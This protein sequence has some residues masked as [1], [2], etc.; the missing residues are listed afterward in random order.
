MM[1]PLWFRAVGVALLFAFLR[2]SPVLAAEWS[3]LGRLPLRIFTDRDGLP[4]NAITAIT[5]AKDGALWVGTKDGAAR[6]NGRVWTTVSMPPG[7]PSNW[8]NSILQASDGALWFATR[9]GGVVRFKD[10]TWT[11]YSR[12]EGL[13][14]TE[15]LALIESTV[16][17]EPAS[18]FAGTADGLARFD[19][20]RFVSMG[21]PTASRSNR[22]TSLFEMKEGPASTLWVGT[23]EGILRFR[24]GQWTIFSVPVP[25]TPANNPV[26]G[27]ALTTA[28]D[29][30]PRL[31][32]ALAY[33]G[34]LRFDAST[35]RP[36]PLIRSDVGALQTLLVTRGAKGAES[37]W[38]GAQRRLLR[39]EGGKVESFGSD[40]GFPEDGF[41]SLAETPSDEAEKALW[42]GM[43]GG[44]LV[45]WK[46]DGWTTFD[47]TRWLKDASVYALLETIEPDGREAIWVG[48]RGG[49]VRI[50]ENE[51]ATFFGARQ[52]GSHTILS[53]LETRSAT[54]ERILWVGTTAG[55]AV[56]RGT[57]WSLYT[58][59]AGL[60][61]S[62]VNT[63]IASPG[64]GG[65]T[66]VWIGTG[67]GLGRFEAGRVR[68]VTAGMGLPDPRVNVLLETRTKAG[69]RTL[70]IGTE[71]GLVRREK[72][73]S[74]IFT[75]REGLPADAILSLVESREGGRRMLWIGTRGGAAR[76]DL[77]GSNAFTTFTTQTQ[78][79]LP[80][81]TVYQVR[82][83]LQER[84]YLCTNKGVARLTP[85]PRNQAE[86]AEYDSYVFTTQ[87]GLPS[88]ECNTGASMVDSKGRIWVGTINGAAVLEPRPG[89]VARARPL[90]IERAILSKTGAALQE[91]ASLAYDQ[92]HV[93]FDFA[94][95]NLFRDED[96]RYRTQLTGLDAEP[97]AWTADAKKEFTSLPEGR[98]GFEVWARDVTGAEAGPVRLSFSVRPAP[99]RTWW[100]YL[101][102]AA[103]LAASISHLFRLR[104]RAARR[105]NEEL[106]QVISARTSELGEAVLRLRDSE[107]SALQ[108]KDAA[109][110]ASRAKS[111]FLA[112]MSHEL[113]TP[114]NAV[115]GFAQV[116]ER[117]D[118]FK[119]E[120][121][122]SL[123]IIQRSGEHLLSLIN[124]VLSLSKI[125]AG[126]L[127]LAAKPFDLPSLLE[128]VRAIIRVRAEAKGLQVRFDLDP[129]LKAGVVGDEGK[130]RQVLINLL[131]NAVKFTDAGVVSLRATRDGDRICFE[132][133][134]TGQ[135]IAEAELPGL[136]GAFVQTR[137]GEESREGTGLGLTISRQIV[138]LMGGDIRVRSRL[139]E[140]SVFTFEIPLPATSEAPSPREG[141]VLGLAPGQGPVKI[142]VVDD[143]DEN[144]LLLKQLLVPAGFEV[145]EAVN[146]QQA[147]ERVEAFRPALVFM[148]ARMPVLDG[149]EA[150][151]RIRELE[152]R[153]GRIR[154]VIVALTAGAFEHERAEILQG[155]ADDFVTKPF[156][157]SLI[158]DK[159][160]QHLGLQYVR[161]ETGAAPEGRR[162]QSATILT[163]ERVRALSPDRRRELHEALEAGH[164]RRAQAAAERIRLEDEALGVAV[165]VEVQSLRF[166]GLLSLLEKSAPTT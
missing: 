32:A 38:V 70:W 148:D 48:S 67:D 124:D 155:G 52:P 92:G 134:D 135:G 123:R 12:A 28:L 120:D 33:G 141:R 14:G 65:E 73:K 140:G 41:W 60:P 106:E 146:G 93:T 161:E 85:R 9:G 36:W 125:E 128:A 43:S 62:T 113:R 139:G 153:A 16:M 87:D 42:V 136:F 35:W 57:R 5:F 45:R 158:F 127:S 102:Y 166:D 104:L 6:Y 2:P 82:Q 4:Q 29:G 130:L 162:A 61:G 81:N 109:L 96:S 30:H 107:Q 17:G 101:A 159:I 78:P 53:L 77:D 117:R 112:N 98:Y 64:G 118:T 116:L 1:W 63:L 74:L 99:W 80:N 157:V 151:R 13:P 90:R 47:T 54:H 50:K 7:C 25:R 94:L 59:A 126:A 84:L 11:V 3:T 100:A 83:D 27:F 103:L 145:Q 51:R 143:G 49:L 71:R 88:A 8:V 91:G 55:L 150:T 147:I 97:S 58:P 95:M 15:A 39:I 152:A 89:A 149:L 24:S 160:G 144:R 79:A 119:G 156:R 131:G 129:D 20:S 22:V 66:A 10:S 76:L 46:R 18:V 154:C 110:Q 132:V 142:L 23:R 133:S 19:G 165:L 31:I 138:A 40:S 114:L 121:R 34:L 137:S 111:T 56:L 75:T 164:V 37:L 115:I 163:V 21:F 26:R 86:G 105:R 122:E 44:G 69:E 72:E 108:A 68:D